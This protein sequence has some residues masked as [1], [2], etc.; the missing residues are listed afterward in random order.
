M[1]YPMP[2]F[3][4]HSAFLPALIGFLA[5]IFLAFFFLSRSLSIMRTAVTQQEKN[6]AR[7]IADLK[8]E[9]SALQNEIAS[10]RA[11]E[12]RLIKRQGELETLSGSDEERREALLEHLLQN[13]ATL[14][15]GL[16]RLENTLLNAIRK[17]PSPSPSPSSSPPSPVSADLGDFVPHVPSQKES[18]REENFEGFVMEQP[19]VKAESAANV[20]RAALN[21]PQS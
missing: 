16:I 15:D 11:M 18:P 19:K 12:S 4:S 13:E 17:S 9:Q 2:E 6:A 20:L 3:L 8:A 21:E 1:P 5:G 7:T 10:L 14:R